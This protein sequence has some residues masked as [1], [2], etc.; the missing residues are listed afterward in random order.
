MGWKT[1]S[2]GALWALGQLAR[3]EVLALLPAKWATIA[4]TAGAVLAIVGV[5]HAIAKA[6]A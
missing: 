5:R 3:P 2:G 6:R 1:I 4:Q